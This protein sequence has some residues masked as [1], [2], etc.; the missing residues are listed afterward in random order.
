MQQQ[1][2]QC[3]FLKMEEEKVLPWEEE[4]N[5]KGTG[6]SPNPKQEN[7]KTKCKRTKN[8]EMRCR[9]ERHDRDKS[10]K[11]EGVHG[12]GMEREVERMWQR[13][14]DYVWARVI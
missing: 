8:G 14:G 2:T 7:H 9:E 11:E 13:R 4:E 12:E 5:G 1:N 3:P 10:A 6:V